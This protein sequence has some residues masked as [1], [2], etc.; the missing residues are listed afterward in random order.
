[1]VEN[2]TNKVNIS[3]ESCSVDAAFA[4]FVKTA[5]GGTIRGCVNEG[6]ISVVSD[7][8]STSRSIY[9]GGFVAM[10]TDLSSLLL[11]NDCTNK[12]SIYIKV[13]VPVESS[14][15]AKDVGVGGIIGRIHSG[16]T[17]K[18]VK[19]SDCTNEKE[20]K[21]DCCE[22]TSKAATYQYS[23]GGIVGLSASLTGSKLVS[24]VSKDS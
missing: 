18:Y 13:S 14:F 3:K 12:G 10:A 22:A 7:C 20:L 5:K 24:P 23:L 2:C 4:G 15:G 8:S 11:V 1:M 6:N 21:L 16:D 17:D 19:I 9:G